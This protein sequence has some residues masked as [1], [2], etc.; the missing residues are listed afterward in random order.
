MSGRASENLLIH[1]KETVLSIE[2]IMPGLFYAFSY[3][4]EWCFGVA[5]YVLVENCDMNIKLFH[6]NGPAA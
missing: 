3:D 2:H 1:Q 5:N 6:P 4:D